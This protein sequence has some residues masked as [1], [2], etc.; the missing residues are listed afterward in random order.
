MFLS[1]QKLSRVMHFWLIS[2]KPKDTAL[3]K[4]RPAKMSWVMPYEW[5]E[6]PLL[7]RKS[8]ILLALSVAM[9][10]I[11]IGHEVANV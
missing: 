5:L 8:K 10:L 4:K 7:E 2:Y 3:C 1:T 9:L 6:T 11:A